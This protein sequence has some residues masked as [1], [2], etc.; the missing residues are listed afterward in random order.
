VVIRATGDE[1]RREATVGFQVSHYRM[2]KLLRQQPRTLSELAACQ[3]VAPP[4]MSR[5]VSVLVKRGWVTRAEAPQGRRR[6]Q[7]CITDEGRTSPGPRPAWPNCC[8]VP[9]PKS[10][11]RRKPRWNRHAFPWSRP[12]AQDARRPFAA[13]S[14]DVCYPPLSQV[15]AA[16]MC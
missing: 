9:A 10:W 4:I 7:L 12:V 3:V 14:A 5:T 11:R 1:I 8:A 6:V 15:F 2:L 13:M 16:A